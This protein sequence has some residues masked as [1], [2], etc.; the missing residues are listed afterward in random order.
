[1]TEILKSPL[2]GIMNS[3]YSERFGRALGCPLYRESTVL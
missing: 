1:M 2:R 3:R